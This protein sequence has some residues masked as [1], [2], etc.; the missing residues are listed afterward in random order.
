MCL[1]KTRR[2]LKTLILKTLSLQN[3]RAV[4]TGLSDFHKMTTNV[5]KTYSKTRSLK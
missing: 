5:L 2:I 4:E 1:T 3:S